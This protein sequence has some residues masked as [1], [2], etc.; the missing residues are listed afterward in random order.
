MG[1]AQDFIQYRL[2]RL[3]GRRGLERSAKPMSATIPI[4]TLLPGMQVYKYK[5]QRR[6]GFGSFGEVWRKLVWGSAGAGIHFPPFGAKELE[7]GSRQIVS[8]NNFQW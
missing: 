2:A 8:D 5:L 6:I 7:R 4:A 3:G 1:L